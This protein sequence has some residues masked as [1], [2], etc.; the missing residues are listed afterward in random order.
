MFTIEAH[1]PASPN[2]AVSFI[3]RSQGSTK[4]AAEQAAARLAWERLQSLESPSAVEST[5]E[6]PESSEQS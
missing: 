3:C 5:P 1:V 2:G 4:K 6:G